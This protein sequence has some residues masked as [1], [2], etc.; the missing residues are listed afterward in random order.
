MWLFQLN[1]DVF[2]VAVGRQQNIGRSFAHIIDIS[3]TA[4]Y[5]MIASNCPTQ[6]T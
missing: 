2:A 3:G 1:A 4:A 6:A 5:T